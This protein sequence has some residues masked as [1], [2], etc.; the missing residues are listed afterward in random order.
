MNVCDY[1][2]LMEASHVLG[3]LLKNSFLSL[4]GKVLNINK[5]KDWIISLME[6]DCSQFWEE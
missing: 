5:H 2:I 4:G 1:F 3:K 6:T